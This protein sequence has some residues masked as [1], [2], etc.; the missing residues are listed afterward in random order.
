[1]KYTDITISF[2]DYPM[3]RTKV[4]I[5]ATVSLLSQMQKDK[6]KII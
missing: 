4:S 6:A 1:V 3:A 5:S 2:Q